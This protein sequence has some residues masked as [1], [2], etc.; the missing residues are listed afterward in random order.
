MDV[1]GTKLAR[2]YSQSQRDWNAAPPNKSLDASRDRCFSRCFC[3]SELALPRGRVNST[4]MRQR[5]RVGVG[6][7]MAALFSA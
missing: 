7:V 6:G 3:K 4:V 1:H 2:G 5:E